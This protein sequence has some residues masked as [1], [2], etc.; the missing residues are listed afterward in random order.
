MKIN[1]LG[2]NKS[3]EMWCIDL[4]RLK[5]ILRQKYHLVKKEHYIQ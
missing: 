2:K 1:I 5:A 3:E 4:N